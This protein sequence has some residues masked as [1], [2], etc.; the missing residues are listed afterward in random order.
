MRVA[1]YCG[2]APGH[3]PIYMQTAREIGRKLAAMKVDLVYGGAHVGTM[4][5][6]ADA[7]LE[8]GGHVIGVIPHSLQ[9]RELAHQRLTEL[10]IVANMHER[11]ALMAS[12]ADAFVALPGGAGTMEEIFEVWTWAQIGLHQKKCALLNLEGFYDSL[13][14]QVDHMV[15]EGL[16][17]PHVRAMLVVGT[18]VD[19]VLS[20][21]L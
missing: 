10:H 4:G 2:S 18:T 3:R 15:R 7:C 12:L 17:Q 9:E 11:K 6:L 20:R 5:A 19:E 8:A 14:A 16:M 1:V 21:T 13:I